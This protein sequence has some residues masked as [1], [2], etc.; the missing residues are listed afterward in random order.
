MSLVVVEASELERLIDS[1]VVKA[2]AKLAPGEQKEVFTIEEAAKFIG[3]HPKSLFRLILD[4]GLPAHY[5]S[6]REPRFKRTELLDW[7]GTRPNRP[8]QPEKP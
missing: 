8:V 3:R 6:D 5:I 7:L 4:E 2:V 1:A